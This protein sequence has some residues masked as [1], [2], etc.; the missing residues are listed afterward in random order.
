MK[1]SRTLLMFFV[2]LLAPSISH[3]GQEVDRLL[4]EY[5]KIETVTCQIRRTRSGDSGKVKFLS[6]VYWTNGDKIHAEGVTPFKRRTIADGKRLF[7]YVEGSSKG[8]SRTVEA[9][10]EPM[11]ISLRFVPGTAMDHLL[12][13]KDAKETILSPEEKAPKRVGI[14]TDK[15]YVVLL[16]DAQDRLTRIDFFKTPAMKELNG[17]YQYRD[18]SEVIP[19]VWVPLTHEAVVQSAAM[20]YKETVKVDRFIANKP[21]AESLFIAPNFFDKGIDFVD[22]FAKI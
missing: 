4:S 3:A 22:D 8:F 1:P 9:L 11:L 17:T 5:G 13:L 6:R 7:Q 2:S 16:F 12:H 14:E 20:T 19:G 18:F 10:S 21:I 15:N